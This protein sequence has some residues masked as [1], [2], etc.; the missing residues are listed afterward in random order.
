MCFLKEVRSVDI[1]YK[2]FNAAAG[3]KESN[4]IQ[5]FNVCQ[6]KRAPLYSSCWV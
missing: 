1:P 3:Y 4:V 2:K 6:K 5:G